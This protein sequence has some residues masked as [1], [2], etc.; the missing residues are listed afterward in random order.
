MMQLSR[1]GKCLFRR[2]KN[3]LYASRQPMVALRLDSVN[4]F[5]PLPPLGACSVFCSYRQAHVYDL[6]G[7]II[8]HGDRYKHSGL[9]FA[10]FREAYGTPFMQVWTPFIH[11]GINL[12]IYRISCT[13]AVFVFTFLFLESL[14]IIIFLYLLY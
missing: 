9:R 2:S 13:L 12:M 10:M 7:A 1:P 14:F 11:A 3:L 4:Q 6:Y 8:M 5:D